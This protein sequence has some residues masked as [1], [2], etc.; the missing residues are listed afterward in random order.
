MLEVT[1]DSVSLENG[2]LR[3]GCVVRGPKRSWVRFTVVSVPGDLLT[4]RLRQDLLESFDQ[5]DERTPDTMPLF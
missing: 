5:A 2:I 3:L 4:Y 1:V